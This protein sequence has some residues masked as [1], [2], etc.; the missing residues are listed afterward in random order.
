MFGYVL[1]DPSG[2]DM[3]GQGQT[4]FECGREARGH[5]KQEM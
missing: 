1:S 3:G 5:T 4:C 2:W